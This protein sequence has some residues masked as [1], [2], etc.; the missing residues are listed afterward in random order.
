MHGL[1]R[2]Y[3]QSNIPV[4][5]PF[6]GK[7]TRYS[8]LYVSPLTFVENN[9]AFVQNLDCFLYLRLELENGPHLC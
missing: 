7:Y 3:K 2:V 1:E 8:L 9:R 4:T 6:A 5:R